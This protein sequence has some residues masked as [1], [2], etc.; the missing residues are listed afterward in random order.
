MRESR[1]LGSS[2]AVQFG[3]AA[4][5][6]FTDGLKSLKLALAMGPRNGV[7][8]LGP[9]NA[10]EKDLGQL[11]CLR[12][13]FFARVAFFAPL[14]RRCAFRRT[15]PGLDLLFALCAEATT[16]MLVLASPPS[17]CRASRISRGAFTMVFFVGPRWAFFFDSRP[18][19][20]ASRLGV[21]FPIP[22]SASGARRAE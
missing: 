18:T 10:S 5:N 9:R 14:S 1:R 4:P 12:F 15:L 16:S 20:F 8:H 22:P 2:E 13:S 7:G 19:R 21:S 17:W 11:M 6:E 3:A